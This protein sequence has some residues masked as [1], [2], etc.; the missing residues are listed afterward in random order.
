[1][2]IKTGEVNDALNTILPG[3]EK[4]GFV[5]FTGDN[6][7]A[8]NDQL[9]VHSPLKTD[10]VGGVNADDFIKLMKSIEMT[11][12]AMEKV[13]N[14]LVI[15]SGNVAGGL[16]MVD[17]GTSFS[18]PE[19]CEWEKLPKDFVG[20]LKLCAFSASNDQTMG[21]LTCI[22]V[23]GKKVYSSDNFRASKYTFQEELANSF[24]VTKSIIGLV[25]FEPVMVCQ[26]NSF[27]HFKLAKGGVFS[28]RKAVGSYPDV[29]ELFEVTGDNFVLPVELKD[30][31]KSVEFLADNENPFDRFVTIKSEDG[32][33]TVHAENERG[34]TIHALE[35]DFSHDV[36]FKINPIFLHEILKTTTEL[37][38]GSDKALFETDNFKHVMALPE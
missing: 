12:M 30:A 23:A 9:I 14:D 15:D 38:L 21:L 17:L 27:V 7:V 19:D 37:T 35:G 31:V 22:N 32:R 3:L 28:C 26:D 6:L 11:D 24:M 5:Y 36:N 13:N 16:H 33:L 18:L 4:G 1:M 10:F 20:A 2:D 8:G 29:D 34:W 25:K